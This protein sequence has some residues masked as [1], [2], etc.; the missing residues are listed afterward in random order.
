[1]LT[2]VRAYLEKNPGSKAVD[3]ARFLKADKGSINSLLYTHKDIFRLGEG[4]QW[5]LHPSDLRIEFGEGWLTSRPFER[6][7]QPHPSLWEPNDTRI[8]FVVDNCKLMLEAQA[9]LLALCNQLSDSKK[10]V[11]LDF[12][13]SSNASLSFL[14]RN[15]FFDLLS[16]D[17]EVLP[18]RPQ[19]GRAKTYRGNNDGVIELRKID[20]A[21]ED[22]SVIEL[23]HK[24]FLT[25]AG[26][27]YDIAAFTILT[28]LYSNVVEHSAATS[29]GFA[30]LQHYPGGKKIQVVISDNGKG[31]VGTLAPHLD[32]RYP[33]VAARVK[34]ADHPGVA[35]LQEIFIHGA[36]SQKRNKGSGL[37][38]KRSGEL[39]GKFQATITVRQSDFELKVYHSAAGVKFFQWLNLARIDG[40]HICFDFR[41]DA[42]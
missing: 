34:S 4:Y 27:S 12:K 25:C 1:M 17:V 32:S 23:L 13:E 33:E 8:V 6:K 11:A 36:I 10:K 2:H 38:L 19:K 30:A 16:S 3:I 39:A 22:A 9:R 42:T 37:G 28:E 41:L 35:L 21:E 24:S 14:D 26:K 18:E 40:T 20:P 7:L 5:F 15:G 31:I 29:H